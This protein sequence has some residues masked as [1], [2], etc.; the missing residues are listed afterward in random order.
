MATTIARH[1]RDPIFLQKEAKPRRVLLQR[2]AG[3]NFGP[4]PGIL[5]RR[6]RRK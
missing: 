6:K 5:Y 4:R 2:N 1:S 3:S